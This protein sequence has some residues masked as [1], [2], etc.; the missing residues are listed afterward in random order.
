MS[1]MSEMRAEIADLHGQRCREYVYTH[2]ACQT[3]K[4]QAGQ[5]AGMA[6]HIPVTM[7]TMAADIPVT[8]MT[9]AAHIPVTMMTMVTW[10]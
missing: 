1:E 7:M 10:P 3:L 5:S 9:M 4:A 6:A 8:M 2:A